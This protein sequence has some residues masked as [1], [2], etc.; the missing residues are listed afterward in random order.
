MIRCQIAIY[1]SFAVIGLLKGLGALRNS[2]DMGRLQSVMLVSKV[3]RV[4]N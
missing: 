2:A 3:I 1:E 4:N